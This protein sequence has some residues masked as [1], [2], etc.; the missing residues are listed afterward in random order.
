M[1]Y[2]NLRA[3][4]ADRKIRSGANAVAV[5]RE[6]PEGNPFTTLLPGAVGNPSLTLNSAV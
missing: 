2:P 6:E 5:V 4:P 1:F 3:F